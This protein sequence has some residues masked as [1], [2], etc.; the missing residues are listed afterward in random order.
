MFFC[1]AYCILNWVDVYVV[2]YMLESYGTKKK[3]GVGVL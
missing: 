1:D 2:S 3:K